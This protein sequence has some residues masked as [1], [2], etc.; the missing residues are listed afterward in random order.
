VFE[1]FTE[2]AKKVMS[3][4]R[5]EARRLNTEFIGTE[6]ILL[7]IIQEGGG[8]AAKVLQHLNV[9]FRL[10]RQEIEK[11]ITPSN[12]PL[13][14]G[15]LPFSPRAKRSIELAAEAASQLDHDV[16]G[17]EHLLL[18]LLK[19]NEGIAAQA[20]NTLGLKL[21][22][23]RDMVLEVLA[24]DVG[25]SEPSPKSS[26][27][28]RDLFDRAQAY[29]ALEDR[30][31]LRDALL[32]LLRDG[33]SIALVGPRFVGKTAL[34]FALSRS[35]AGGVTVQSMDYRL[36][37][38]F[39]DARRAAPKRTEGVLFVPEGELLTASRTPAAQMLEERRRAG[40][41]LVVEFR[42][43]GLEAYQKEF[44]L[45]A[46]E[47]A[48]IDVAPPGADECRRLLESA[49]VRLRTIL[50]LAVSDSL[51]AEADRMARARWPKMTAPWAT[52]ITLWKAAALENEEAGRGDLQRLEKDVAD[53]EKSATPQDRLTAAAL[54]QH[55]EGLRGRV[56]DLRVERIRQAIGE[57]ADRPWS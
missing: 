25:P 41:R 42:D 33:R 20:L 10:I 6:G 2:R 19:E 44:P 14:M 38:E 43:G 21:D 31:A 7:G 16:I 34:L 30:P 11:L 24:V 18:G 45:L 36:L 37:D 28:E 39:F 40:Q 9:D 22:E 17:T 5:Q 47:L 53:L 46:R 15:Q 52:L 48:R 12:A 56:T 4:A 35:K 23:V 50:S 1:K 29:L 54:R 55:V 49:R 51:L 3:L 13:T 26:S 8:V 57:L 32:A 27:G